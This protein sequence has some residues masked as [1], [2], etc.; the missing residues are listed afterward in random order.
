MI[1]GRSN[2]KRKIVYG[3]M[4]YRDRHLIEN[5]F[6]R[7]KDFRRVAILPSQL[8]DIDSET[9]FISTALW[10]FALGRAVLTKC[11]TGTAFTHAKD[12]SHAVNAKT[13]T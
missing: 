6:C 3:K 7:I 12:L 9:I 8:D 1:P 13:T 4:R 2:R 10:H 11:A 5:A